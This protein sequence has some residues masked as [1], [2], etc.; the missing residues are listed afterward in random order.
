[1]SRKKA[2]KMEWKLR[3]KPDCEQDCALIVANEAQKRFSFSDS[4]LMTFR[5]VIHEAV[6]N[7]LKYGGGDIVL[8]VSGNQKELQAEISQKNQIVFPAESLPFKGVALIRRH[9]RE[10]AFSEDKKTLILRF[11]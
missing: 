5:L 1:M 11:Y 8:T 7:A 10:I 9:A 6:L 4:E 3:I 2:L